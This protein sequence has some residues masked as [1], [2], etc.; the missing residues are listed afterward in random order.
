[1]EAIFR[2]VV[3]KIASLLLQLASGAVCSTRVGCVQNSVQFRLADDA[4][5]LAAITFTDVPRWQ[6]LWSNSE[7]CHQGGTLLKELQDPNKRPPVPREKLPDDFFVRG[8][9]RLD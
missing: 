3:W 4:E 9:Q 2:S 1:M 6:K 5:G 8:G 7:N